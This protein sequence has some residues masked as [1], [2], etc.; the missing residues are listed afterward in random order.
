[1]H[2]LP[3]RFAATLTLI[4][5]TGCLTPVT[6]REVQP[7]AA[8]RQMQSNAIT[9]D[10]MS[11][12]TAQVLRRYDLTTQFT[13]DPGKTMRDLRDHACAEP[14]RYLLYSMAELS[15]LTARTYEKKQPKDA[16]GY[17]IS[18]A[19]FAYA[20][21]FD[22][23]LGE[24]PNVYD[25]RFRLGCELYNHSLARA[26]RLFEVSP[27]A[28]ESDDVVRIDT[29]DGALRMRVEIHGFP[30]HASRFAALLLATDY[31][32]SGIRN[33]YRTYGLGIPLIAVAERDLEDP[34]QP[35][36][37]SYPATGILRFNRL[38]CVDYDQTLEASLDLYDPL[39]VERAQIDGIETPIESDMTTPLAYVLSDPA[40]QKDAF[41]GLL[42]AERV[43]NQTGLYMIEPY[44]P[45]RIPVVFVH[46]LVSSPLTWAEMLNDLRGDP[47]LREKYQFWFYQYPTGLPFVYSAG[48]FRK[49]LTDARKRYNPAGD[50][51]NFNQ[52]VLVGHS[53]GGLLSKM[54]VQESGEALWK[55]MSNKSL[56]DINEGEVN[57]ELLRNTFFYEPQPFVKRVVF[58]ATPHAG[59]ELSDLRI[60]NLIARMIA[61]PQFIVSTTFDVL[62]LDL[63]T[64]AD[65]LKK[66]DLTSVKN[67]SPNNRFIR[68]THEQPISTEVTYHSVIG[69]IRDGD[70]EDGSDGIV[71]YT[72]A[73]IE[74]AASEKVV[75][76]NHSCHYHPLA[77]L[78]VRRILLEH[79]GSR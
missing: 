69:N 58:M 53:M 28:Q 60:A 4:V 48:Q 35:P 66:R 76:A 46:G 22:E 57:K 16:I 63:D 64:P 1:M 44:D 73:H 51:P 19:R 15:Y 75:P 42:R 5:L 33:Q 61:V 6:L 8:F 49:A 71:A 17:F 40:L 47:V 56:D 31:Q 9:T 34:N 77:I 3:I 38:A 30:E 78:E 18:S 43:A 27:P 7:D 2:A 37:A 25:P 54:M 68:V 12:H 13:T 24:R 62:T 74:G 45:D 14:D 50:N 59:S 29:W 36:R 72:S 32:V 10:T 70:L 39:H 21:L 41:V 11:V 52:M 26:L 23:N 67:L 65:K 20:F 55:T 79:I